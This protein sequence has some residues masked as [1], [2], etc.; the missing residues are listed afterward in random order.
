M[1]ETQSGDDIQL[2]HAESMLSNPRIA[3][4]DVT[5]SKPA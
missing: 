5:P 3:Q 2:S 4:R 1:L